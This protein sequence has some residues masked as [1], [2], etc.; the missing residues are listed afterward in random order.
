[1]APSSTATSGNTSWML[2]TNGTRQRRAATQPAAPS[3]SGGDMART[4]SGGWSRQPLTAMMAARPVNPAKPSARA[5]MFRLLVGNGW[6]R[7]TRSELR[8]SWRTGR[9]V[10]P[11]S[12]RWCRYHG[13]E[14]TMWSSWPRATSSPAMR[15][16]TSPVGAV[17]GS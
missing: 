2:K 4:T 12:T 1:M 3:V 10:Q 9:P 13:N 7:V 11:G 17:S 16:I 5:G 15:V 6:T 14:V 8:S